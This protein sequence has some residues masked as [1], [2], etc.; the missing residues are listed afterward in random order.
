MFPDIPNFWS[1][2]AFAVKL[3]AA[4]AAGTLAILSI[5]I[6]LRYAWP[7]IRW[8]IIGLAVHDA[9]SRGRES[10]RDSEEN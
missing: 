3:Q 4:G 5:L 2:A 9:A 7:L 8:L 1:W 6:F 10:F